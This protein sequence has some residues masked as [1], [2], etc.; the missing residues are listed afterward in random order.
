MSL[1]RTY[2]RT[3]YSFGKFKHT[4]SGINYIDKYSM[5]LHFTF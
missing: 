5:F 1:T 2:E 3:S 4:F